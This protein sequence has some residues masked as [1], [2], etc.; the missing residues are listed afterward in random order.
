MIPPFCISAFVI[1]QRKY[2]LIK[3][4]GK[5]L[6]GTWQMVSGGIHEGETAP[7]TA[8]REIEEETALRPTRLYSADAVETFYF[9]A[10]DKI[11]FV[12][13]FAAFV[14][15][16]E[17]VKLAPLE[18]DAYAWLPFEEARERLVF[19]EQRRVIDH[20]HQ[21]FVLKEPDPIFLLR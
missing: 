17:P 21:N 8:L 11:A 19:A 20:I 2:L 4:C 10:Q 13:V 15:R 18:H 16:M 1:H 5:Y 6:P 9:A 14:D 7:Q 12:P 3:R